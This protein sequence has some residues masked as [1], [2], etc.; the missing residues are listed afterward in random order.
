MPL[1]PNPEYFLI[2]TGNYHTI[3]GGYLYNRR[4]VE[5]LEH[6]KIAVK[7]VQLPGN[8]PFPSDIDMQKAG[9]ILDNLPLHSVLL[10]DSL[11]FG[12][13][14]ILW[15]K[16]HTSHILIP[17]VHLPVFS[18][19]KNQHQA[20]ALRNIEMEAMAFAHHIIVTSFFTQSILQKEGI[21]AEKVSVIPPGIDFFGKKK[22]YQPM[23]EQLLCVSNIGRNK[24]QL[25]IIRV[26]THLKHLAW[27]L[28]LVGSVD[29]DPGYTK[30]IIMFL[31]VNGLKDRVKLHGTVSGKTLQELYLQS[32]LFI[33]AS[34]FET[35]GMVVAEALSAGLPVIAYESE[36]VKKHFGT[37]PV[38]F[39]QDEDNLQYILREY[40]QNQEIYRQLVHKTKNIDST[41]FPA[42]NEVAAMV[43]KVIENVVNKEFL[44]E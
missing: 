40:L 5:N 44:G 35:Y 29:F 11:V 26:L 18:D 37:F 8:Y 7:L 42:W 21:P 39:F 19:P 36:G 15:K 14:G 24:N 6:H 3:T 1:N 16:Y 27:T 4:L 38:H 17:L 32:D 31:E 13:C 2:Y 25:A 20:S 43:A 33:F 34:Q 22:E 10:I 9:D 41:V 28:H 23:P 30:E 12:S